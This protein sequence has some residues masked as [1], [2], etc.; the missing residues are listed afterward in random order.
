MPPNAQFASNP[1]PSYVHP[2][3][4]EDMSDADANRV[5]AM[6]EGR[7]KFLPQSRNN[8]YNRY[9]MDKLHAYDSLVDESAYGRRQKTANF[10]AVGTNGGGGQN[11]A[12]MNTWAQHMDEYLKLS[13]ELNLGRF[14]TLNEA[15]NFLTSHGFT[16]K[17]AQ[18]KLGQLEVTSK[19]VADEGA[20]VMAG[21]GSA[22]ADREEWEKRFAPSTPATVAL[23]KG[24]EVEKLVEGRLSSLANQY[25]EGMRTN[26]D[27]MKF[28]APKT[29]EIM[30]R[31]KAD[32]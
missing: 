29:R 13:Q 31:L 28:V 22:L 24:K 14:T 30:D 5:K 32:W 7:E 10:F 18:D 26:H 23:A 3:V 19:A 6:S 27:P 11:I 15:Y 2:E 17:E 8:P 4:L 21:S 25:N 12:A 16:S 1:P 20:K 9:L